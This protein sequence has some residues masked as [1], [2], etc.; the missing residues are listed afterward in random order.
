MLVGKINLWVDQHEANFLKLDCSKVKY[1]FD[2]NPRWHIEKAIEKT[3]EWS[4]TYLQK[5]NVAECMDKQIKD[6]F[7]EN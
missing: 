6:F 4:K 5:G 3:I 1:V 7:E 2:W